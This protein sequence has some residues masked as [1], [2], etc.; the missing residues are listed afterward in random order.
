[1]AQRGTCVLG[2][3]LVTLLI[4]GYAIISSI[5]STMSTLS[6]LSP[7]FD[8]AFMATI[9]AISFFVTFLAIP[10]ML[11]TLVLNVNVGGFFVKVYYGQA[12]KYSEPYSAIK[13][14]FGRK[15][16]GMCWEALWLYLWSIVFMVPATIISVIAVTVAITSY[17][18]PYFAI[19]ISIIV[20]L[21]ACI[22]IMI[23]VLSYSMTQYILAS[24]PNVMATDALKLSIRMTSGHKGKIFVMWLSFIGWQILSVFT[25]GIL[26]IF[27]VDPYMN[28]S[29][30]GLF[31]ELRSLA[32]ASGVI[33]PSELDGIPQQYMQYH[34]YH[35]NTPEQSYTGY[36]QQPQYLPY[37]QQP[38]PQAQHYVPEPMQNPIPQTPQ[39]VQL[40]Q[41]PQIPQ[42][43]PIPGPPSYKQPEQPIEPKN[44]E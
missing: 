4:S 41:Q 32:V 18:V 44:D 43:P 24:N 33:H 23:K 22:P 11:I 10:V 1:M 12:V 36:Q 42:A 9:A 16:G 19:V 13:V 34:Q 15:L 6:M 40:P 38:M 21:A 17:T 39:N 20:I 37:S 31:V 30:A 28:T 14:N 26:G 29:L 35:Q 8:I 2:L 7:E 3:F 25:L 5:P 27:Y